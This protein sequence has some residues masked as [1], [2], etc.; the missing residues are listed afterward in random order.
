MGRLH[1]LEVAE[2]DG[3][4]EV[5]EDVGAQD[6]ERNEEDGRAGAHRVHGRED[7]VGEGEHA[8]TYVD[9]EVG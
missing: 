6:V 5:Q 8:H 1:G 3:G 9:F 7:L 4:E 2:Q